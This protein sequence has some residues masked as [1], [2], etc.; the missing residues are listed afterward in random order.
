MDFGNYTALL[1]PQAEAVGRGLEAEAAA[2]IESTTYNVVLAPQETNHATFVEARRCLNLLRA[3]AEQRIMLAG[4]S[5]EA[6]LLNDDKFNRA[7]SVGAA[8]ASTALRQAAI[9]HW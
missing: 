7:D 8:A 4:S 9:R 2:H 5:F 1:N 6:E 3:P